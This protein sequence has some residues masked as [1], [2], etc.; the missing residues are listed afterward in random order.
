MKLNYLTQLESLKA[1][2][3]FFIKLTSALI[4]I[5]CLSAPNPLIAQNKTEG[6]SDK[7]KVVK[8]PMKHT[9]ENTLLVNSQTTET[10]KKRTLQFGIQHRFGRIDQ[11]TKAGNNFDL[12][13]LL[14]VANVR[15][16]LNYGITD[17]LTI[18]LGATKK[19]FV[20]NLQWK[21]KILAQTKKAGM[22]ISLTYFGNVAVATIKSDNYETFS[23]RLSYFHQLM[24]ARKI[25]KSLSLQLSPS[26]SYFNMVD[27]LDNKKVKH[28]NF[29]LSLGGR[30]KVSPSGSIIFEFNQPITIS[31]YGDGKKTKPGIGIGYEIVTRGHGFQLFITNAINLIDQYNMVENTNDFF[32]GEIFIG[33]NISRNWNF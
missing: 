15:I 3:S 5:I 24:I 27:T 7:K 33:F 1:H 18:G 22:P 29:G 11:G 28:L 6:D 25:T 9:F 4:L 19:K 20:Y 23:N 21:Y 16:G 12:F 26:I 13:G 17:R 30:I 14:G 8:K 32:K 10:I 31:D 2:N